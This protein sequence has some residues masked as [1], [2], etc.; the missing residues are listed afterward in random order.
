MDDSPGSFSQD[1]GLVSKS[2]GSRSGLG[3]EMYSNF[4]ISDFVYL[5]LYLFFYKKHYRQQHKLWENN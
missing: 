4:I 2:S 5:F 1:W 3:N